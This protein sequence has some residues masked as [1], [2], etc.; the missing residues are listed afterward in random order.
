METYKVL[1]ETLERAGNLRS[2]PLIEPHDKWIIRDGRKM[3][4]LS[5][6]DYLGLSRDMQLRKEFLTWAMEEYLPL[7]S[8]S[9]RLLTGNYPVYT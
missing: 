1:L 3:L 2:L 6:N 9:S 4:N 8:T 7:S 5:S